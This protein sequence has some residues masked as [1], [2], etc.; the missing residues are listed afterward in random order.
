VGLQGQ[1]PGLVDGLVL[2]CPGLFPR[3]GPP[4]GERLAIAWSRLVSPERLFPVP[5][6]DAELFTA[7]PRWQEFIR[8]DPLGLRE[9]TA[10]FFTASVFLDR[11]L[12]SASRKMR[13]PVLLLLAG[14]DRII[15]NER[16]RRYVEH[17]PTEDR[18]ILEYPTASHTLE[19]EADPDPFIH[20]IRAWVERH[21]LNTPRLLANESTS[22]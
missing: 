21:S 13:I 12:R 20:D 16:T 15:D 19:F 14:K 18:E 22:R 3:V 11:A 7:T 1:H 5:L 6:Q 9:A 17:F 8:D 10:R 2:L 4:L